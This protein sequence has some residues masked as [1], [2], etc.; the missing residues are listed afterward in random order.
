MP[1]KGVALAE[2]L[3]GDIALRQ[4]G[5]IDLLDPPAELPR[6]RDAVREL[7]Y[8][9]HLALSAAEER[10]YLKSGYEC[11]FDGA[12]GPNL[13]E[14]QWAIQ[15]R[16]YAVDFDMDALVPARRQRSPSP[17]IDEYA[18]TRRFILVL[19]VH[20]AKHVWGR[21]IWLCDIARIMSIPT[22]DW[23]WIAS[24]AT[25]LGNR[26]HPA[27]HHAPGESPS[28]R[29]N[30]AGSAS[31]LPEIR[32]RSAL[33]EKFK[34]HIASEAVIQRRVPGLLPPDDASART[35]ARSRAISAAA[36]LHPRTQR[37]ASSSVSPR[38][39]FPSIVWCASLAWRRDWFA[40]YLAL[41]AIFTRRVDDLRRPLSQ[42]QS[43]HRRTSDQAALQA[44][45]SDCQNDST[46]RPPSTAS[47][48][49]RYSTA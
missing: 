20:A 29:V 46:K 31:D 38:R 3:Y 41:A 22:L 33:V 40:G 2:W 18:L 32:D 14:V 19:S 10:A 24:Q 12:A 7:G 15:P 23:T 34:A 44:P 47:I 6:I 39:C 26:A 49:L 13:L 35:A 30:S 42:I 28:G 17:D 8:T 9:P 16:F 43:V 45:P 1:Y 11:A 48:P 37:M 25:T 5:D 4:A 27:R 21:L 36:C